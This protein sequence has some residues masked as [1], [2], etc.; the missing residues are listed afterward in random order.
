MP[1]YQKY[2]KKINAWVKYSKYGGKT[3]IKNVKER[4]P[5]KRFKGVPVGN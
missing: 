5:K 4:E 3:R 1:C 2:N